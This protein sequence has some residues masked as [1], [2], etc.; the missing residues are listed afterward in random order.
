M[1][2]GE[3]VHEDNFYYLYLCARGDSAW[4]SWDGVNNFWSIHQFLNRSLSRSVN[5]R[6]MELLDV[7]LRLYC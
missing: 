1:Q 4:N 5:S 6:T 2:K 7:Y 3:F